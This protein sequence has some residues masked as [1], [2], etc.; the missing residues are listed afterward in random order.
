M[1]YYFI[2][3]HFQLLRDQSDCSMAAVFWII[4]PHLFLYNVYSQTENWPVMVAIW[5]RLLVVD[6]GWMSMIDSDS[7]YKSLDGM[8]K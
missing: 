5:D 8:T 6:H 1:Q 7:H 3:K 2:L 4:V